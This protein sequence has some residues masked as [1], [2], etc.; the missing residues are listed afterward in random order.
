MQKI[1]VTSAPKPPNSDVIT[2]KPTNVSTLVGKDESRPV[3]T[4][5]P[6]T[7]SASVPTLQNTHALHVGTA[8][9]EP[10]VFKEEFIPDPTTHPADAIVLSEYLWKKE[11]ML[12]ITPIKD[13]DVDIWSGKVGEYHKYSPPLQIKIVSVKGSRS[14]HLKSEP[15]D[16]DTHQ[17]DETKNLIDHAQSLLEQAKVFVTKPVTKRHKDKHQAKP[18]PKPEPKPTKRGKKAT[19]DAL[20]SLHNT[21]IEN[22]ST[23]HVGT[24]GRKAVDGPAPKKWKIKCKMCPECFSSVRELN[25]HHREDHGVVNCPDCDK[26]FNSQ[27][28]LDKH[29]YLH[30]ELKY[31]CEQCGKRFPFESRL[32]QHKMTH[33]NA[34]LSCPKKSCSAYLQ[35]C[36]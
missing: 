15:Y 16:T 35:E 33:I 34:R 12:K 30:K 3:G 17:E 7:L 13:L 26:C 31:N 27:S 1:G 2:D 6:T 11:P 23:L 14:Q 9:I 32:E 18:K 22:L 21:T 36:W 25:N 28:S 10:P 24:D 5:T 8:I 20:A 4:P 19:D 29:S